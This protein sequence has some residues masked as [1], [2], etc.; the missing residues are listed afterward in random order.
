MAESG[1][2]Q[3]GQVL[4]KERFL[5]AQA[6]LRKDRY[7]SSYYNL[8]LNGKGGEPIS[9]KIWSQNLTKNLSPGDFVE[10]YAEV[11]SFM[12][13]LQL[14]I[15]RYQVLEPGSVDI[16]QYV[17]SAEIDTQTAFDELFNPSED[18]CRNP[19]LRE[20]LKAF[21]ANPTFSKLF[22][23]VPAATYHHHNY[24][25]GLVEHTYELRELAEQLL[26]IYGDYVDRDLLL[27]AIALHDAGKV[28]SYAVNAGVPGMSDTGRL[29]DHLFIGASMISNQWD[30]LAKEKEWPA[31]AT[32]LK[33]KL[34]HIVLSH[35]GRHDW[36][37]PVLPQTLE[38]VL[39]HL[40]DH[41]NAN[42]KAALD[43]VGKM[44]PGD[45][46]SEKV[47]ILEAKRSFFRPT[48]Q[49]DKET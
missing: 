31:S 16:S 28:H 14:S 3:V 27:T 21:H 17:R 29:L 43:C 38:A 46:W 9:G 6:D 4:A 30:A 37:S 36:G 19:Y 42:M 2:L 25:G 11:E 12:D 23:E 41:M 48:E 13:N 10:V 34:L 26:V 20:L 24:L 5:V 40:C 32:V 44:Q 35:H 8:I 49:P 1:R 7:G 45:A 39:V 18:D 47:D 33:H 22:R 15:R